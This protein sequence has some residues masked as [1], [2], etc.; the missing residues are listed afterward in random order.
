MS[1]KLSYEVNKDFVNVCICEENTKGKS[2]N[3]LQYSHADMAQFCKAMLEAI[4]K[5]KTKAVA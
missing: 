5:L 4:D 2:W 1:T 3:L